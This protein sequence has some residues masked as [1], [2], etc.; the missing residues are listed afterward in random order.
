M[1]AICVVAALFI[2]GC[3]GDY[4]GRVVECKEQQ[5]R[6]YS[7]VFA[8]GKVAQMFRPLA[9]N[10]QVCYKCGEDMFGPECRWVLDSSPH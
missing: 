3:S 6:L 4:C 1:K 10:Q 2:A 8:D 5:S 9:S 7:C